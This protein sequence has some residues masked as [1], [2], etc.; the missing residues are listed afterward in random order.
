MKKHLSL[1]LSTTILM[2]GAWSCINDDKNECRTVQTLIKKVTTTAQNLDG[3]TDWV[4]LVGNMPYDYQVIDNKIVGTPISKD[5]T[6]TLTSYYGDNCPQGEYYGAF[7][8]QFSSK[9]WYNKSLSE[10]YHE[11]QF[12]ILYDQ[13]TP[14][15]LA[16]ADVLKGVLLGVKE[17]YTDVQLRYMY[18]KLEYSFVD[19]PQDATVALKMVLGS[20]ETMEI[21]TIEPYFDTENNMYQAILF[22]SEFSYIQYGIEV[23]VGEETYRI[24]LD[25]S[26]DSQPHSKSSV[27][28]Q[29]EAYNFSY[30][31]KYN[32][33]ETDQ[34]KV[35]TY[36]EVIKEP[37][38]K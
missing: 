3:K 5:K 25:M 20:G 18:D 15:L 30:T 37:R 7:S 27:S 32:K 12:G 38:N 33:D 28:Y 8:A 35:L 16:D 17:E 1:F 2:L 34:N 14:K 23:V 24:G 10:D 26:A 22:F 13:H 19:L 6:F 21:K 11:A 29:R 36:H 4:L 31:I 9:E